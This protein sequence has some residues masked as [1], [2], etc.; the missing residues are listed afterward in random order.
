MPKLPPATAFIEEVKKLA[1]KKKMTLVSIEVDDGMGFSKHMKL[2][3]HI[4]SWRKPTARM[5]AE[6]LRAEKRI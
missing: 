2:Q 1:K 3:G 6:R 4:P 5:R